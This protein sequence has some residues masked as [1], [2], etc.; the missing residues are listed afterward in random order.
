[1]PIIRQQAT[2]LK[3]KMEKGFILLG[4]LLAVNGQSLKLFILDKRSP[5]VV[6]GKMKKCE[7]YIRTFS[8]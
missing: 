1:M 7:C 6:N 4:L 5:I 8:V 2:M 3:L